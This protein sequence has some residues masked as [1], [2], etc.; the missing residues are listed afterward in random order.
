MGVLLRTRQ[1][2]DVEAAFYICESLMRDKSPQVREAVVAVLTE[3]W[4]ADARLT[5]EFLE[6]WRGKGAP[7][8]LKE[9]VLPG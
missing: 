2:G 8:L 7:A 6:R 1:M 4:G 9:L 5:R 3:A